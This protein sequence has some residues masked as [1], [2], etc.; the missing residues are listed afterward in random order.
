MFLLKRPTNPTLKVDAAALARQAAELGDAAYIDLL[1]R[2]RK[3]ARQVEARGRERAEH[4][5]RKRALR[6]KT[7]NYTPSHPDSLLA[8]RRSPCRARGP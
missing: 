4:G 3:T 5:T 7:G 1:D 2:V 8:P 6:L